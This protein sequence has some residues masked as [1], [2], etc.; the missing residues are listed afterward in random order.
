[1]IDKRIIGTWRLK[2]TKGVDDNGKALPPPYGPAP[3]G[4][5]CFQA[6]A[7]MYCVLCDGRA[8]LPAGEPRQFMSYAGNYTFD[9][10]TLSTR[11]DASV[12]ASRIGGDQVRS[13]RFENGGMMLA[14]PRR[15]YLGVMQRQ[16]LFWERVA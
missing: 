14:P 1:M 13:V 8:E 12:D 6:D 10:T 7:R 15:L 9:G 4:V 11:V 3:N 16:E 5:V 2:S